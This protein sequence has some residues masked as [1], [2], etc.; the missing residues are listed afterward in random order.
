MEQFDVVEEVRKHPGITAGAVAG[1]LVAVAAVI[2][3]TQRTGPT[4]Y[5][6]IKDR[7]DPRGWIDAEALRHRFDD[8]SRG[9]KDGV[10]DL[11]GRAHDF[12]DDA[13]DRADGLFQRGKDA[14]SDAF[15]SGKRRKY[16]KAARGY[17]EDTGRRARRYAE[18]GGQYARDHAREGGALLAVA[19]LAAAIGAAALETRRPDS[20]IRRLGRF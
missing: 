17:A 5:R 10:D 19:T 2:Y 20:K 9:L 18:T 11:G 16:A 4:R 3:L 1:A 14:V 6:V 13:R 15:S 12:G 7:F 8:I